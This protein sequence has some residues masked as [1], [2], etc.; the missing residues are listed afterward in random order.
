M[1][2]DKNSTFIDDKVKIGDNV[3]IY[4]NNRIEGDSVI[5]DN[6]TIFPN[7]YI[8]DSIIGKG[9][10]IYSSFI[11]K[12]EIG[13]CSMIGP[14]AHLRT[15]S[16]IGDF[17]RIGNFCETKNAEIG[18]NTKVSHLAYVGDAKIGKRCNVG[19]GAI[20][21]NFNGKIKQKTVVEDG[22]FIGSNVNVIAPVVI[23]S[24]AYVCAGTTIDSDV[25]K[26]DF[27]IGR[28]RQE[29]KRGKATKYLEEKSEQ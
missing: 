19:C 18:S 5:G 8:S 22:V 29:V 12:S 13:A 11:E 14:F 15:G 20:F 23:R 9:T 26:D 28:V 4:E 6:V 27:V 7:S 21:V 3:I 16:K 10:K 25:D 17:V 24:G 1:I 2:K